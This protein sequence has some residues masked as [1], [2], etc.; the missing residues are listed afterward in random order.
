MRLSL[1]IFVLFA[2]SATAQH[3]LHVPAGIPTIQSAIDASS[4]GDT[5]LVAPGTYYENLDLHGKAITLQSAQGP[6]VTILDG[7][8]LAPTVSFLTNETRATTLNGFTI[9]NG[10][11]APNSGIHGAGVSLQSA[12]PT[13]LNNVFTGNLCAAVDATAS[14]PLLQSNQI[15]LTQPDASCST[16]ATAPIVLT[17]NPADPTL[18]PTLLGNTIEHNDLTASTLQPNAGGITLLAARAM[19]Q[20]NTIRFNTTPG[21]A[22][23]AIQI[24]AE[25]TP[26][27]TAPTL[28]EQNLVYGN[29]TACGAGG[30][31]LSILND[32]T[33]TTA[34]HLEVQLLNNTIADD[35]SGTTCT[36]TPGELTLAAG[37]LPSQV[38]LANN[39]L[40][41]SSAIPALQCSVSMP[42]QSFHHNLLH[43]TQGLILSSTCLDSGANHLA[44][45]MFLDRDP[46]TPDYHV[47]LQSPAVD[48][49]ADGI[50]P[51]PAQDLDR[52]PRLQN[53]TDQ[54]T[55]IIDLG[56]YE[57]PAPHVIIPSSTVLNATPLASEAFQPITLTAQVTTSGSTTPTGTITFATQTQALATVPV[58]VTGH[59]SFTTSTLPAASYAFQA[60][61]SGSASVSPSTTSM[62]QT[63]HPAATLLA[64]SVT[65]STADNAQSVTLSADA[66]APLSTRVPT[67]Q[68]QFFEILP[69]PAAPTLI[70]T[71]TLNAS[72]QTSATLPAMASGTHLILAAYPGTPNFDPVNLPTADAL[73]LTI[74]AHGY[75]VHP[76]SP[77]VSVETQHHAAVALTLTSLGSFSGPVTLACA[78]LPA[79]ATCTFTPATVTLTPGASAQVNLTLETDAVPN[80]VSSLFPWGLISLLTLAVARHR[81]SKPML[82]C[83]LVLAP[84]LV[85]PL[86]ACGTGQIPGHLAPG[87]YQ[88]EVT[89]QSPTTTAQV[90]PITLTVTP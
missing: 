60:T 8:R 12:S 37:T 57:Y 67:G 48:S 61:F 16:Q 33:S 84:L 27:G 34:P 72:G 73:T 54:P 56:P 4:T 5:V 6:S 79:P 86:T 24:Y 78:N 81:G 19:L 13:L 63:V 66:Q 39:I 29:T 35:H 90:T 87:T 9:R 62:L 28:I 1:I 46:S 55:V 7:R 71:T 70:T 40:A 64:F 76:N 53:A 22:P 43:N 65:P 2:A 21:N 52:T 44:D 11:P 20:G 80:F 38:V 68:V 32:P 83:L 59:A 89:S 51:L 36:G 82:V 31:A 17:G 26:T 69:A 14:A 58:D 49:G 10:A 75:A 25:P 42:A 88:I 30:L 18:V 41:S 47:H 77:T 3:T 23:G 74:G 50:S 85:L 45:P 15:T